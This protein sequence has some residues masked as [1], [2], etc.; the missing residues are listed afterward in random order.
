MLALSQIVSTGQKHLAPSK[1]QLLRSS[2]D[3]HRF[4]LR[5]A[6]SVHMQ[7]HVHT[8]DERMW[9]FFNLYCC[10]KCKSKAP[11]SRPLFLQIR[12]QETKD[13][14]EKEEVDWFESA[15]A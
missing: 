6:L 13:R 2:F 14:N 3:L 12:R 10:C 15:L 7:T 4:R 1:S 11:F 8:A 9:N 5:D